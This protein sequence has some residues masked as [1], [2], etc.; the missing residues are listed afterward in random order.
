[1]NR[2]ILYHATQ[3][4]CLYFRNMYHDLRKVVLLKAFILYFESC[5][6]FCELN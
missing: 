2:K 5:V 1:M 4:G 3:E 6:I